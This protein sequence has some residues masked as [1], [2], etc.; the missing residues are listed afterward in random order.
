MELLL[1]HI[2]LC[3]RALRNGLCAYINGTQQVSIMFILSLEIF[4]LKQ[5]MLGGLLI[6]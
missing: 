6:C 5:C 2:R 4:P 1:D 3:K